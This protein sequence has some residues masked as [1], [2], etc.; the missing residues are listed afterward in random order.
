MKRTKIR[1]VGSVAMRDKAA[2]VAFREAVLNR[3]AG[4]CERC[5]CAVKAGL[6]AHHLVRRARCAGWP[7]RHNPEINGSA[8]C[9][10]CHRSLTL[11]P[12][13]RGGP[14]ETW[15]AYAHAAFGKWRAGT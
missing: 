4:A 13:D 12:M 9:W 8:V 10:A 5:L 7:E 2:V 1:R 11:D 6:E 15:A 14:M 3:A